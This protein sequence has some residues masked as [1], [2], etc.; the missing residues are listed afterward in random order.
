MYV[1]MCIYN[2]RVV[3]YVHWSRSGRL[4][5]PFAL[6]R[7]PFTICTYIIHVLYY[8]KGFTISQNIAS[9]TIYYYVYCV[10]FKT[11]LCFDKDNIN[12]IT[13]HIVRLHNRVYIGQVR[14]YLCDRQHTCLRAY[15]TVGLKLI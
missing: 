5:C 10:R 12:L 3:C 14:S 1:C 8:V 2:L 13:N 15:K 4:F 9:R 6:H 7:M 11:N